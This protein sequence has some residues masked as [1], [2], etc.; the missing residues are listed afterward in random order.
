MPWKSADLPG[1]LARLPPDR[2][3]RQSGQAIPCVAGWTMR[4]EMGVNQPA[5][6]IGFN[7]MGR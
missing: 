2:A 5:G 1:A 6:E 3:P 7:G 4:I